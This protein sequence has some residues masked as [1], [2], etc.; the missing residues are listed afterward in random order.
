MKITVELA[1]RDLLVTAHA[2][3]DNEP[4]TDAKVNRKLAGAARAYARQHD[5]GH[6]ARITSG[7]SLGPRWEFRARY[8]TER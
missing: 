8:V 7:A 4:F 6:V 5:L 2:E 3:R 1:G